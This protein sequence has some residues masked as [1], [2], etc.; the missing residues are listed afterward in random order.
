MQFYSVSEFK[1][2][3]N[4]QLCMIPPGASGCYKTWRTPNPS[5]RSLLLSFPQS[6]SLLTPFILFFC[7]LCLLHEDYNVPLNDHQF[8]ADKYS[9][10]KRQSNLQRHA[11]V[12]DTSRGWGCMETCP[13]GLG[14]I[15]TEWEITEVNSGSIYSIKRHHGPTLAT[16]VFNTQAWCLFRRN[17]QEEKRE[18]SRVSLGF[19]PQG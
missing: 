1:G 7:F 14:I 4:P 9:H 3:V 18:G 15:R 10:N 2:Q 13:E 11:R 5:I 12:V 19:Y 16:H 8:S 17:P 6:P